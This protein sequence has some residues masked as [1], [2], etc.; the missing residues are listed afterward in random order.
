MTEAEINTF[1]EGILGGST[2]PFLRHAVARADG[3]FRQRLF[4]AARAGEGSN[5]RSVV[6]SSPVSIAVVNGGAD[7]LVKLGYLD[8][9]AYAN[10]WEGRCHR[11]I[12]RGRAP[13][14]EAPGDFDPVFERF[15]RDLETS[16]GTHISN[17]F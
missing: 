11:L 15:L 8:N 9:V 14:W 13:F 2:E 1:V 16:C 5:Q 17:R 6:A 7:H 10:L 12:E 4:E 3:R